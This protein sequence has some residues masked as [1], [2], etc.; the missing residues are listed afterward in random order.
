MD[1]PKKIIKEKMQEDITLNVSA[2][3]QFKTINDLLEKSVPNKT[4]YLLLILSSVIITA[5]LLLNNTAIVIGGM[6]VTPLLTP[7]LVIAL[8]M[9]VGEV[10]LISRTSKFVGYSCLYVIIGGLIMTLLFQA[11]SEFTVIENSVRTALLYFVVA[12]ASGVAATFAWIRR[13][14]ADTLPGVAIAVSLVPP[15]ALVGIGAGQ[16]DFDFSLFYLV[17]FILNM[18]GILMGSLV[19]FSM[20]KFH[21]MDHKIKQKNEEVVVEQ[22]LKEISKDLEKEE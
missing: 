7:I 1:N 16:F 4:Y 22:H 5:G 8:G 21:R 10:P 13:E 9:S 17:I 15:L 12:I 11:P 20:S 19:V 18:L 2:R 14:V 6:L 3:D